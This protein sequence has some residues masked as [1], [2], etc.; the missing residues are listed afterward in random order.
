M[1]RVEVVQA[2]GRVK[3]LRRSLAVLRERELPAAERA[4]AAERA[5]LGSGGFDLAG[6]LQAAT[7]L[8]V[9]RVDE[10]RMQG[11]IEH[12]V[13]DFDASVGRPLAGARRE[14]SKR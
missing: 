10:A 7:A 8:R 11:D 5:S 1:A 4:V 2:A 13:V 9:A 14:E 6:W 3:A 12:A